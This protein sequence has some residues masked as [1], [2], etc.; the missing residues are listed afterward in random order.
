MMERKVV[1]G[2]ERGTRRENIKK[3][4]ENG[5]MRKQNDIVERGKKKFTK[6]RKRVKWTTF[7]ELG[8]RGG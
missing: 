1:K 4:E 8:G 3:E 2:T 7:K 6:L 5:K